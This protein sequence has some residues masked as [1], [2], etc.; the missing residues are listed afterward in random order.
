MIFSV[1]MAV[2]IL[3]F[4]ILGSWIRPLRTYA[5]AGWVLAFVGVA[6]FLPVLFLQWGKIA[7]SDLV[8]PLIQIAMFGMGAT[9]TV[10]D[11]SRVLKLPK[12]VVVG[13]VLQFCVMPFSGWLLANVFRLP[14]EVAV[15]VI[16]I[17][18]C[19]GGVASNVIT[20]LAKGN[21][22]LSVTL[23]AVSTLLAPIMTPLMMS[24]LAGKMIEVPF[25]AMMLQIIWVVIIPIA[26]GLVA[27]LIAVRRKWNAESIER[28][29]SLIAMI[30]IC[31]VC[32]II[33]AK[34]HGSLSIVGPTLICVVAI[35]NLCG[36]LL[37]YWGS[38]LS[39][40]DE[41]ACRTV[42]I[43]VGMQNGGLGATLA[44]TVL[45]S[46]QAALASAIFAPWMSVTGSVLAAWWRKRPIQEIDKLERFK[47]GVG[48]SKID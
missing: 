20:Y 4:A 32:A 11:F 5:F 6:Y 36:Y 24:L 25:L 1:S 7:C 9:L 21:V 2:V 28:I 46:S 14:N 19:P 16:L 48:T 18:A 17:G 8:S 44:T 34:A 30:A 37:G 35:H 3:G 38:R 10:G 39:G 47:V 27:N 23:T 42:A 40:L 13:T 31:L 33:M 12:A 26:F 22:A 41:S 43:E 45:K 29:L 15:G